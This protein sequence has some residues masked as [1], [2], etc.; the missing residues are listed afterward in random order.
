MHV[1]QVCVFVNVCVYIYADNKCQHLHPHTQSGLPTKY[2]I[3]KRVQTQIMIFTNVLFSFMGLVSLSCPMSGRKRKRFPESVSFPSYADVDTEAPEPIPFN[4]S[5]PVGIDLGSVHRAV[6]SATSTLREIDFFKLFFTYTIVAE[7]CQFTNS[8]GWELVLN[9]PSYANHHGAWEEVTPDEFYRFLGLLIYMGF[10]S[11]HSIHRYWG[12]KSLQG[13]WAKLFMSRD[14]FKELMAA[15]HVVDPATENNL[16]RLRKLRYLMDHLKTK[17]QQLFQA[18]ENLSID[19]RMVKSKGRS[20]F[21]QYMKG[22]PTR[23]GFKLWVIAT[24]NSGYTLDFDVYTGSLDGRITDLAI[25]VIEDLVQPFKNQGHTVWFDNF[26]TS[27]TVMVRLKEWGI[28]AC[29]TCRI[30]RKKFPVDFK[31]VKKWERQANR[32]DMRWCRIDGNVLV[33]QWKDTRAVTCLSN[34]HNANDS[35]E[36]SKMVKVGAK[37]D[38]KVVRQP[39]VVKDYNKHMGGVDRSDQMLNTYSLLQKTQ[40]VENTFL[41]FCGHSHR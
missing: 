10:T 31:D 12:T 24:S 8:K 20:G 21:K 2:K 41:P 36:V 40:V 9:R 17:C 28:N 29:G 3:N 4:P 37:W 18:D 23:W 1:F 35:S 34:F 7:I 19:E 11:L 22:K 14:R 26:Y 33:V 6:R 13:S 5:R 27:P 32:G 39:A 25:K 38:R 30:N 16:D 15:L